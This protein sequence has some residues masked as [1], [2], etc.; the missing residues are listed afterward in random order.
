M[1]A[2]LRLVDLNNEG[3]AIFKYRISKDAG[4]STRAGRMS[5]NVKYAFATVCDTFV[6]IT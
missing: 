3:Q 4:S 6:P 1:I 5:V 2:V